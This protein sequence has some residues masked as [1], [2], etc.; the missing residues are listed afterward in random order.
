MESQL[1]NSGVL[2]SRGNWIYV[3]LDDAYIHELI[4][5]IESYGFEEPPYFGDNGEV[6]AHISVTF[7]DELIE[8]KLEE[9]AEIIEFTPKEC[10]IIEYLKPKN[11]RPLGFE[12]VEKIYLIT[13]E[14]PRLD[15][16]RK[17]YG[18]SPKRYEFHITIGV[19]V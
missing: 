12:R 3:D 18:L 13:V 17:R 5:F 19:A 11:E 6:G 16:I 9:S 4:P 8:Q 7:P 15:E 14:A 2:K 10:Q 1:A